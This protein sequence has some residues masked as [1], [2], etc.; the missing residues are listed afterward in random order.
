[1][2]PFRGAMEIMHRVCSGAHRVCRHS[3]ARSATA[4][5]DDEEE[6]EQQGEIDFLG[7][8]QLM[9]RSAQRQHGATIIYVCQI[10][11]EGSLPPVE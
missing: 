4:G 3:I 10:G 9:R 2:G 8:L 6:E 7:F 5:E 11:P 1:M